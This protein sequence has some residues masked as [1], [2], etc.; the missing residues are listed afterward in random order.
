MKGLKNI[1]IRVTDEMLEK[2]DEI[3]NNGK[4]VSRSDFIRY[5]I[6]RGLERYGKRKK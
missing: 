5:C 6:V 1:T 3:V 2:I 4:F